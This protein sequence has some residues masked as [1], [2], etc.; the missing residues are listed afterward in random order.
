MAVARRHESLVKGGSCATAAVIQDAGILNS[1]QAGLERVHPLVSTETSLDSP[2]ETTQAR[3]PLCNVADFL[4]GG[5]PQRDHGSKFLLEGPPVNPRNCDSFDTT[6]PMIPGFVYNDTESESSFS[7][8]ASHVQRARHPV[9]IAPVASS[10]NKRNLMSQHNTSPPKLT[11]SLVYSSRSAIQPSACELGDESQCES[12]E[13][14]VLDANVDE[15][16]TPS[17]VHVAVD[18]NAAISKGRDGIV[19]AM[20][21]P[22][23][24]VD[25][26][27]GNRSVASSFNSGGKKQDLIR[28]VISQGTGAM[29]PSLRILRWVVLLIS[30]L[31]IALSIGMA[32][33]RN[34][35]MM[36]T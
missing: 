25:G 15:M 27:I 1:L 11:D 26:G 7:R 18:N 13:S 31:A 5:G 35:Y 23:K 3:N 19:R 12:S 9:D 21:P 4:A 32:V 36:A 22:C 6:T 28:R 2:I 34:V 20:S 10:D 16:M 29:V 8:G 24:S 17:M 14:Q 33:V 30:L